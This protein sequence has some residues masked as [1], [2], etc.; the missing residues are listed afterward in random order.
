METKLRINA[1]E[2][3]VIQITRK[4]VINGVLSELTGIL[5]ATI[6]Q[7]KLKERKDS[8]ARDILSPVSGGEEKVRMAKN[9]M[10][11]PGMMTLNK[12]NP[13]CRRT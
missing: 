6:M 4:F 12:K 13:G 5:S 10:T 8:M 7:R 9:V 3:R 2:M 1:A 11:M